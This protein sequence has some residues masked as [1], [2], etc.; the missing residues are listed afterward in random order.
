MLGVMTQETLRSSNDGISGIK[1]AY[2]LPAKS[3]LT[4]DLAA[5]CSVRL[6]FG[7]AVPEPRFL[8][9]CNLPRSGRG[10]FWDG[11]IV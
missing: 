7:I 3:G 2:D 8:Q 6:L 9:G 4:Y 11:S 5:C 10:G 1:Q